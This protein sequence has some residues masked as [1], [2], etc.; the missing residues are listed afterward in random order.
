[1]GFRFQGFVGDMITCVQ[2]HCPEPILE[3]NIV[4]NERKGNLFSVQL[5]S[6]LAMPS[7]LAHVLGKVVWLTVDVNICQHL[8]HLHY[9]PISANLH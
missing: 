4:Q 7:I 9:A 8:P 5:V 1:M 6:C 2:G 3:E